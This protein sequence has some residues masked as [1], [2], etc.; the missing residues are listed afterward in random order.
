M[1]S[2]IKLSNLKKILTLATPSTKKLVEAGVQ[3][4]TEKFPEL[5]TNYKWSGTRDFNL[6]LIIIALYTYCL[7]SKNTALKKIG[8]KA[9]Q[10]TD[11]DS[12]LKALRDGNGAALGKCLEKDFNEEAQNNILNITS[13]NTWKIATPYQLQKLD[14][15]T[16]KDATNE[17]L[18]KKVFENGLFK[19]AK[20][21]TPW[22]LNEKDVDYCIGLFNKKLLKNEKHHQW[23]ETAEFYI[24]INRNF[25]SHINQ[26]Y[27]QINTQTEELKKLKKEL[28]N[29]TLTISEQAKIIKE[30][31][32][33]RAECKNFL[34]EYI[35]SLLQINE[36][37][38]ELS[39]EELN[40]VKKFEKEAKTLGKIIDDF[41]LETNKKSFGKSR[42]KSMGDKP[43]SHITS[44]ELKKNKGKFKIG[45][46]KQ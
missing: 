33:R 32:K 6:A 22:K 42:R 21:I 23:L 44:D 36:N 18:T 28:E 5:L 19:R 34:D 11:G 1:P 38:E 14:T 31:E 46:R 37:K 35:N 10:K 13:E 7:N 45:N 3:G 29:S 39:K 9:S 25:L 26:L 40:E 20:K 16:N 43:L 17:N 12:T 8:M 24:S 27:T 2:R 30:H 4:D 15:T 41:A